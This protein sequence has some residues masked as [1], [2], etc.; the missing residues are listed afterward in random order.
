MLSLLTSSASRC[1]SLVTGTVSTCALWLAEQ[2]AQ[3]VRTAHTQSLSRTTAASVA[4]AAS[5]NFYAR[6]APSTLAERR[7]P[8]FSR[9]GA[10]RV[11]G[12]WAPKPSPSSLERDQRVN[13]TLSRTKATTPKPRAKVASLE[14]TGPRRPASSL[15]KPRVAS[16]ASSSPSKAHCTSSPSLLHGKALTSAGLVKKRALCAWL[17]DHEAQLGSRAAV[18]A[19]RVHGERLVLQEEAY[20]RSLVAAT[21][22][23]PPKARASASQR[24]ARLQRRVE[25]HM[26]AHLAT[27]LG[28]PTLAAVVAAPKARRQPQRASPS[29]LARECTADLVAARRVRFAV[30]AST[31]ECATR[32]VHLPL[33]R[34]LRNV[35][36]TG[37]GARRFALVNAA[38]SVPWAKASC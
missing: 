2:S 23:C 32:N 28:R 21:A 12:Q 1:A 5:S 38:A 7:P 25:I 37:A 16:T 3:T 20:E 35:E 26:D 6:P 19:A 11:G 29:P 24:R 13:H 34:L 17:A 31:P 8:P 22:C 15:P 14:S 30:A 36:S 9:V 4:S 33:D 10:R 18:V 27:V